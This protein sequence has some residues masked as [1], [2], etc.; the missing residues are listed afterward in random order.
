MSDDVTLRRHKNVAISVHCVLSVLA[1][2]PINP[3]SSFSS[4]RKVAR[5]T[6]ICL[7]M[8][9]IVFV[10]GLSGCGSRGPALNPVSGKVTGAK[11]SL[12]GVLIV[13]N[14]LDSKGMSATG[15]LSADG[16]FKLASNN[17]RDGAVAGKYKV[18]FAL[19]AKAMKKMM[20]GMGSSGAKLPQAAGAGGGR[21]SMAGNT[22]PPEFEN[23][24]PKEYSTPT[25]SPKDFE[26]K[27]GK[28]VLDIS[29]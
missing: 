11:G 20:E 1:G 3:H 16:T 10:I 29:L 18:T 27:A 6:L 17:D 25:T 28:N 2:F 22:G 26:V 5:M 24:F 9:A 7:R 21:G 19:G 13:L 4:S 15:E 14:P 12:E 8:F 23:P